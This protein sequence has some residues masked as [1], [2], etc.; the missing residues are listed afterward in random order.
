MASDLKMETQIE[1]AQI[2]Q[3]N[4][5]LA[6]LTGGPG[7]FARATDNSEHFRNTVGRREM[8]IQPLYQNQTFFRVIQREIVGHSAGHRRFRQRCEEAPPCAN[9]IGASRG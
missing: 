1:T 5:F 6:H 2:I 3:A 9:R 4:H 8:G 7:I